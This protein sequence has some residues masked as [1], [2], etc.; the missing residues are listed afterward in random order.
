MSRLGRS[1]YR[2]YSVSVRLV[3]DGQNVDVA[4]FTTSYELNSIPT[5]TALLAVGREVH[6]LEPATA[7]ALAESLVTQL[8]VDVYIVLTPTADG[9]PDSIGIPSL[10]I[11]DLGCEFHIFSGYTGGCGYRKQYGTAN[12]EVGMY[13]WLG[14][15]NDSSILSYESHP[16]NPSEFTYG[17]LM[18]GSLTGA[19]HLTGITQA[20]EFITTAAIQTDFWDSA[21]RPLFDTL[22]QGNLLQMNTRAGTIRGS[23]AN[24]GALAALTK[25]AGPNDDYYTPLGLSGNLNRHIVQQIRY[26]ATKLLENPNFMAHHTAWDIL[27]GA[28]GAEFLFSVVPRPTS[29][30]VVPF[31]PGMRTPFVTIAADENVT[32]ATRAIATRVLRGVGL[33]SS[34]G[35]RTGADM[36]DDDTAAPSV[37]GWYEGR[38]EGMILTKP[39]PHWLSRWLVPGVVALPSFGG[40]GGVQSTI[41]DPAAGDHTDDRDRAATLMGTVEGLLDRYAQAIYAIESI[42]GRQGTLSGPLRFDVGPGS[43]VLVEGASE[44]FVPR[45]LIGAPFYASVLRVTVSID[46]ENRQAGCAFHLDHIRNANENTVDATSVASH[47]LWDVENFIGCT[48][49]DCR[50]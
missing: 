15:M 48:L 47:P 9:D 37:G 32:I 3:I 7:H 25:F 35:T 27:V 19:R 33:L 49:V 16:L 20:N 50:G 46:S 6:S 38:D 13:H 44:A 26:A 40:V 43:V 24:T 45:D 14:R 17:A 11:P 39:A 1:P 36:F 30:L 4:R 21:L 2:A 23:H 10:D 42:K 8:P 5:A 31:I 18:P 41:F 29:A 28:L 12:F 34:V 22:L